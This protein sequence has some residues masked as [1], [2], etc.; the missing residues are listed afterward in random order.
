MVNTSDA[1]QM[2]SAVVESPVLS[3]N[4]GTSPSLETAAQNIFV[5]LG[6]DLAIN[7]E[8]MRVACTMARKKHPIVALY[9]VEIPHSRKVNEPLNPE[10]EENA[11]L[12]LSKA[13][14]LAGRFEYED[15]EPEILQC[16]NFARSIIDEIS[17]RGCKLLLIGMPYRSTTAGTCKIDPTLDYVLE[18]ATC[19]V[20]IIR[21]SRENQESK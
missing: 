4:N 20:W 11:R 15:L 8:I 10:A 19:R 21:G 13:I 16:R 9:G 17:K 18:H 6:N 12:V 1:G 3:Q 7:A 5:V 2:A 14:E